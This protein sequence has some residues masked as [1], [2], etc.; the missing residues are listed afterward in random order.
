VIAENMAH[1]REFC[2]AFV[3]ENGLRVE[4]L[5]TSNVDDIFAIGRLRKYTWEQAGF[6]TLCGGQS[7]EFSNSWLEESDFEPTTRHWIA[8]CQGKII[9]SS[10]ISFHIEAKKHGNSVLS[11]DSDCFNA[12]EPIFLL[13]RTVVPREFAQLGLSNHMNHSRVSYLMQVSKKENVKIAAVV[14]NSSH[15]AKKMQKYGFTLVRKTKGQ[16]GLLECVMSLLVAAPHDLKQDKSLVQYRSTEPGQN[17]KLGLKVEKKGKKTLFSF[18]CF[19]RSRSGARQEES[20]NIF[21]FFK[22]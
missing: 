12:N 22:S 3:T 4:I 1:F 8:V 2:S 5:E 14:G 17:L 20:K 21:S 15:R 11:V 10:R 7:V 13:D 18:M 6:S 19:R 16:I 9:G